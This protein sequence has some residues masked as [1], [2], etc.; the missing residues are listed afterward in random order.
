MITS[1]RNLSNKIVSAVPC[2]LSRSNAALLLR[3][4]LLSI[5]LA[6]FLIF[7]PPVIDI[8]HTFIHIEDFN[9][10]ANILVSHKNKFVLNIVMNTLL[11]QLVILLVTCAPLFIG[12]AVIAFS[13]QA[14]CD[15]EGSSNQ[16]SWISVLNLI[17]LLAMNVVIICLNDSSFYFALGL[18]QGAKMI[19]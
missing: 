16:S 18:V 15:R 13:E 1:V 3:G 8:V 4:I 7:R 6:L 11:N 10:I 2:R 17:E 12:K 9:E 14:L 19:C 5:A